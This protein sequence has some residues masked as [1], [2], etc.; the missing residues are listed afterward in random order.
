MAASFSIQRLVQ[1]LTGAHKD[2]WRNRF[3]SGETK[4]MKQNI[5]FSS[6]FLPIIVKNHTP[7]SAFSSNR[8]IR[9]EGC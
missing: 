8:S 9:N 1:D 2:N 6:K 4:E 5:V 3:L 7:Q